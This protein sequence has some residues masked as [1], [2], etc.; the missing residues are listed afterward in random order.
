MI[1]FQ[2][3]SNDLFQSIDADE[4]TPESRYIQLSDGLYIKNVTREDAGEYTCKAFQLS[5]KLS[6]FKD[7]TIQLDVKCN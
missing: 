6:D 4:T 7:Q 2:N 5:S 3:I 1:W